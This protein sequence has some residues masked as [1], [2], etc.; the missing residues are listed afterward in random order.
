MAAAGTDTLAVTP[1]FLLPSFILFP[2][3]PHSSFSLEVGG[4]T[5]RRGSLWGF[6]LEEEPQGSCS[7]QTPRCP[8]VGVPSRASWL[9]WHLTAQGQAGSSLLLLG[10]DLVWRERLCLPQN[11]HLSLQPRP[12]PRECRVVETPVPGH[13]ATTTSVGWQLCGFPADSGQVVQL[14]SPVTEGNL[15]PTQLVIDRERSEGF[16][17]REVASCF[18]RSLW[19]RFSPSLDSVSRACGSWEGGGS[20]P[21]GF[22]LRMKSTNG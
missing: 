10:E 9:G 15:S 20:L 12:P 3:P 2:S 22:L 16:W 4:L 5:A 7:L 17:G 14:P 21:E 6:E 13:R 11:P 1:T 8:G 18:C 19:K